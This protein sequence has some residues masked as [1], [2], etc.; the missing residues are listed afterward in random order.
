MSSQTKHT[1][2]YTYVLQNV[3]KPD[4]GRLEGPKHVA[5]LK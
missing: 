4:N 3:R 2:M 5:E 1:Y